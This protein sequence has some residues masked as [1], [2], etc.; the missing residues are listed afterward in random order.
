MPASG[1]FFPTVGL[2]NLD[3]VPDLGHVAKGDLVEG[4]SLGRMVLKLDWF[5]RDRSNEHSVS[6]DNPIFSQFPQV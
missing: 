3:K 6:E 5:E 2:V 1:K 4:V